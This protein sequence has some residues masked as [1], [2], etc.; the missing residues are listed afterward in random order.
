MPQHHVR[1]RA[2]RK[3]TNAT[4]RRTNSCLELLRNRR[5]KL[6]N[7]RND[8]ATFLPLSIRGGPC[9]THN[10]KQVDPSGETTVKFTSKKAN[11]GI[12]MNRNYSSEAINGIEK[13]KIYS[14]ET[15]DGIEMN[16]KYSP[17]R[18]TKDLIIDPYKRVILKKPT[19]T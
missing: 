14:S 16:K 7:G 17:A 5:S 10:S 4:S 18:L 12:E 19:K 11:D 2:S 8:A 3:F 9:I 6:V 15:N 13:N 1:W